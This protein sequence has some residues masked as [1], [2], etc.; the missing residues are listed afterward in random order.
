MQKEKYY[1][2]VWLPLDV[3]VEVCEKFDEVALKEVDEKTGKSLRELHKTHK[4]TTGDETWSFNTFEEACA[5][6]N[7][8]DRIFF[9]YRGK[10]YALMIQGSKD[11]ITVNVESPKRSEIEAI[12]HVFEKNVPKNII[13][14][15]D[16]PLKIFIGHGHDP[17]WKELKKSFTG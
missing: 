5:S 9:S 15:E 2:K 17:Q 16:E 12:F 13:Q 10:D 8:A 14:Q 6:Y 7:T 4:I 1:Y 11:Y 3:I